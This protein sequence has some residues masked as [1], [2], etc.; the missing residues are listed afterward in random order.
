MTP[1]NMRDLA[2]KLNPPADEASRPAAQLSLTPYQLMKDIRQMKKDIEEI[3]TALNALINRPNDPAEREQWFTI[4]NIGTEANADKKAFYFKVFGPPFPKHGVRI[5]PEVLRAALSSFPTDD[6]LT[7]A[8]AAAGSKK[9]A[10]FYDMAGKLA[11][12]LAEL[13][14]KKAFYQL[15]EGKKAPRKI[16]RIE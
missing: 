12:V 14:G 11:E 4:Q 8:E 10:A 15:E 7:A 2:K 16:S 9:P 6:E 5:W 3:K 1:Q 13:V